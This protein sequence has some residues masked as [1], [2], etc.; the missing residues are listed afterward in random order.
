ML[1]AQAEESA[2]FSPTLMKHKLE[3]D[4]ANNNLIKRDFKTRK[5]GDDYEGA[6]AESNSSCRCCSDTHNFF[7]C[8][9]LAKWDAKPARGHDLSGNPA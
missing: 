1:L 6:L 7:R 5:A 4:G 3:S 8:H 9:F 2:S